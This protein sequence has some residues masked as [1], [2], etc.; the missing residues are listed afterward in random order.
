MLFLLLACAV[1]Q[2]INIEAYTACAGDPLGFGDSLTSEDFDEVENS[3][4]FQDWRNGFLNDRELC[5]P[6]CGW[7]QY[8]ETTGMCQPC[9]ASFSWALCDYVIWDYEDINCDSFV[10]DSTTCALFEGCQWT[11]SACESTQATQGTTAPPHTS[12]SPPHTSSKPSPLLW[13]LVLVPVAFTAYYVYRRPTV[14]DDKL[15]GF[16]NG[17]FT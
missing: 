12:P 13:L 4:E 5:G 7:Y 6:G 14:H 11:G 9:S 15:L 1:A 3:Q 16:A 2:E 8:N 17:E 10:R